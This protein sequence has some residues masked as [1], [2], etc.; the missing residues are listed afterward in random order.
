MANQRRELDR[1]AA[2]LH[3]FRPEDW[4]HVS[5]EQVSSSLFVAF[6]PSSSPSSSD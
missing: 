6:P 3:V 5:T 4:H 2:E 1:I